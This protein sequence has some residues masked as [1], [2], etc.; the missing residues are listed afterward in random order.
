[1][2]TIKNNSAPVD[3]GREKLIKELKKEREANQAKNLFVNMISH[4][5][6][7]PLAVIQG[8]IDLIDHRN[9]RLKGD[10]I[11]GYV[12][13][14]KKSILRMTHTMDSILIFG[15]VQN[16]QL[17]FQPLKTDIVRFCK[18][19]GSEIENLNDGRKII[20]QVSKSLPRELDI[21][22]TL[23]YHIVS[24][25][26]SNA[27][28]YSGNS[29][30]VNL[31]LSYEDQSLIIH[32][33]DFGIG[34]PS[35]EIRSIFKLFHRGSNISSRKG[36]GIGM[37]IVKNCVSLHG[38]SIDVSSKENVGTIFRVKLPILHRI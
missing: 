27:V 18:N 34:I 21:D 7:A 30:M 33:Q 2:N 3:N 37:F 12:Q 38:G 32:V 19:I 10:E 17:P 36:M 28:K 22:T 14:I 31:M 8:V 6:R 26:L 20:L 5:M 24:N 11:K 15:R 35:D 1:M 23:L 4:E 9:D 29:K 16:N 13:S 25:L